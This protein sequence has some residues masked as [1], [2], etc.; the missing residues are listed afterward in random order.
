MIRLRVLGSIELENSNGS[1]LRA[2]LAQPK[3][4]ALLVYL[5]STPRVFHR[6]D[7]LLA[8]FSAGAR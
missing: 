2:I 1:E 6:R 5:A 4:F 8:L 7:T 3:R